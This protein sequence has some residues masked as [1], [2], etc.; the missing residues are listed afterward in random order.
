MCI[1]NSKN[2]K[3]KNKKKTKKKVLSSAPIPQVR[4]QG[5]ERFKALSQGSKVKLFIKKSNV[6][7][8]FY[9]RLSY[10]ILI[11]HPHYKK[12]GEHFKHALLSL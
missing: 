5:E 7:N 8:Y 9:R 2:K 10:N 1:P 4:R 3:I 6:L 11:F 12:N